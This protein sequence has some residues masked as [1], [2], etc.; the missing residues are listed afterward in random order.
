[1]FGTR[2]IAVK[3]PTPYATAADFCRIFTKDMSRL[4]LLS[5]LLTGDQAKAEKCFVRGL[6]ASAKGNPV[7]KEW[8]ESWARRTII[9]NAIQMI[10]PH[11]SGGEKHD[12][13]SIHRDGYSMTEP[14]DIGAAMELPAFERFTFVMSMLEGYSDQECSLLL[15]CT[16]GDVSRARENALQQLGRSAQLRQVPKIVSN[17]NAQRESTASSVQLDVLSQLAA[18]A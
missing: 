9:Q 5:L 12:I 3:Q 14:A 15:G 4:Y 10:R 13:T 2:K 17:A 7:F 18:P 6:D 16:R 8:A 1:M 11:P